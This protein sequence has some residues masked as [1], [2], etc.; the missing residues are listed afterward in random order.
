MADEE[1]IPQQEEQIEGSGT[2]E[3][4]E[5]LPT[6]EE[7]LDEVSIKEAKAL[8]KLLKDPNTQTQVIKALAVNAKII[9]IDGKPPTTKE[10][11]KEAK[12]DIKELIKEKLGKDF[13]FFAPKL[14]EVIEA[15][16]EE[17]RKEYRQE[18]GELRLAQIQTETDRALS[19][20][21]KETNGDSKKLENRIAQLV[22]RYPQPEGTTIYEYLKEMYQLAGGKLTGNST[23]RIVDKI[24]SNARDATS[25]LRTPGSQTG[26]TPINAPS[27]EK[28]GLK[29]AV[30]D[31]LK[32]ME[33][34]G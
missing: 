1:V 17:E 10:E 28:R 18:T 23:K 22:D 21:S 30:Q 33:S 2:E 20:L 24:Q 34:Q 14:A 27:N 6:G 11:I 13:E 26:K 16:L 15:V 5:V 12:K 9:D 32:A 4:E 8:Y 19:K 7:E 25:R 29:A 31:A 3:V